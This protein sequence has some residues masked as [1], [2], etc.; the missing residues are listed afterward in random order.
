MATIH[1]N[2]RINDMSVD[3]KL[4]VTCGKENLF[5]VMNDVASSLNIHVRRK[6]DEYWKANGYNSRPHFLHSGNTY[7]N[8]TNG[9]SISCYDFD[10][11]SINFGVGESRALKVFPDCGNDVPD[12][13]D[14]DVIL[15]SI[16]CW[17]LS[18][19]IMMVIAKAL[20]NHGDVYY[21]HNDCDD[22]DYIKLEDK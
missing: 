5:Q 1:T 6:L 12:I 20:A 14:G 2:K 18:D 11:I 15:F 7:D 21:D 13:Y 22:E 4:F 16:G 8:W 3:A 17:G 19:E 9:V 10:C